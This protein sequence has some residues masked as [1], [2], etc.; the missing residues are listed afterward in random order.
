MPGSYSASTP[1][2]S[3]LFWGHPLLCGTFTA[4]AIKSLSDFNSETFP[5]GGF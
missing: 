2:I 5:S 4:Q 1:A 3:S